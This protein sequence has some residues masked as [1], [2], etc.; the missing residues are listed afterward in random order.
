MLATQ[1]PVFTFFMVELRPERGA[2]SAAAQSFGGLLTTG[3]Q[4]HVPAGRLLII[5]LPLEN[6]NILHVITTINFH[7]H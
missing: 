1:L 3:R 7:L 2:L 6:N 5:S 4:V